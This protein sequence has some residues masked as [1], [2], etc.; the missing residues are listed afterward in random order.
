[1]ADIETIAR[2]LRADHVTADSLNAVKRLIDHLNQRPRGLAV[3]Y[4]AELYK[5]FLTRHSGLR[6]ISTD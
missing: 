3:E 1:M 4:R 2:E 6:S 5:K